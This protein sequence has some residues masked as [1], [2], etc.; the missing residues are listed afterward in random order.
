MVVLPMGL[1]NIFSLKIKI[2]IL[3][4]REPIPQ[5]FRLQLYFTHWA[6]AL[7]PSFKELQHFIYIHLLT[8][9]MVELMYSLEDRRHSES[10]TQPSSSIWSVPAPWLMSSYRL[11]S[12]YGDCD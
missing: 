12:S 4:K 9:Y 5:T 3:K 1:K 11:G 6:S 10:C 7:C 2:S 8:Q